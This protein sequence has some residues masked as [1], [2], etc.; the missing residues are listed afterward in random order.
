[1]VTRCIKRASRSTKRRL[2]RPQTGVNT[3]QTA[4]HW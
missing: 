2:E 4:C 1:M 3:P